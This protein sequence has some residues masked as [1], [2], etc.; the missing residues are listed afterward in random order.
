MNLACSRLLINN[1]RSLHVNE[2]TRVSNNQSWKFKK[3]RRKLA[4]IKRLDY[5]REIKRKARDQA[6]EIINYKRKELDRQL[7]LR[8]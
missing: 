7:S 2:A 4:L 3:E 8:R 5:I 6:K 1:P